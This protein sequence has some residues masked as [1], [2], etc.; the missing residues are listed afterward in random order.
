M[1]EKNIIQSSNETTETFP[2]ILKSL[3]KIDIE[4]GIKQMILD[5]EK[6]FKIF[7]SNVKN[8]N[9]II[10]EMLKHIKG[11]KW[12]IFY[13]GAGTSARIGVQDGSELFPTFGWPKSRVKFIIAGG[14]KA[15]L[16]SIENAEDDIEDAKLQCKSKSISSSD[17]VIGLSAS[18]ST[19]FTNEVLKIATKI[20]ACTIGITNNEKTSLEKFSKFCLVLN[21]GGELIGGSTRLK[22]GTSQKIILNII[23]T[24]L[25][26]KLGYVK[27]GLMVNLKPTN[28]KLVL[29]KIKI[30][31]ALSKS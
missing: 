25:F 23:S 14:K 26:S 5:Q 31:K 13:V 16:K 10:Y 9:L 21:T 7:K 6:I 24:L 29:R 18:G 3:D 28:K 22:A 20:G 17:V 27:D 30:K 2:D 15:L 11:K 1:Y 8:I 12:K 4:D 19:P